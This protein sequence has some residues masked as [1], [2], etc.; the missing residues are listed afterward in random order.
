LLPP[1]HLL[2]CGTCVMAR[3]SIAVA[4]ALLF[5]HGEAATPIPARCVD[6]SCFATLS[7]PTLSY[8]SLSP[9]V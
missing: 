5:I 9:P 4:L 3:L 8:E 1:R 7:L 6:S 2:R